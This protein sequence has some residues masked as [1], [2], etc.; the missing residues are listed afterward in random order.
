MKN[1]PAIMRGHV[2]I[3]PGYEDL[4]SFAD[5]KRP[6]ESISEY[7]GFPLGRDQR[8]R[9]KV[10]N[11]RISDGNNQLVGVYFKLYGYRRLRRALSR[12]FKPTRS[13]A[14]I[15]NLKFFHS[16]GIKACTPILQGEYKNVFGIARNCMIITLEVPNSQQLDQFITSL[17]N[18]NNTTE[19]VKVSIRQQIL[20][21][22]ATNLRKIHDRSFFHDDL[23]WRNILIQRNTPSSEHVEVFWIDCPNGYFDKWNLRR[24]HGVIKDLATMD[25]DAQ[26]QATKRER[27]QFLEVYSGLPQES[28][29]FK[30][31]LRRVVTYRKNHID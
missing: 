19:E 15:R 20:H 27:L 11:Q 23:K 6:F 25:Y 9:S 5:P 24:R 16:I 12:I 2:H 30:D 18:D 8:R 28:S 17:E 10:A 14:E 26:Y 21:S 29:E 1:Q 13:K 22:V 4:F 31:L 7:F 3:E